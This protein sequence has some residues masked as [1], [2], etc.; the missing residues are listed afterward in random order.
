MS[1]KNLIS[2]KASVPTLLLLLLFCISTKSVFAQTSPSTLYVPLIG[3]TSIP[4]SLTLPGVGGDVTYHYAIKNFLTEV[5]LTD[6]QVVDDICNPIIFVEGD[7]NHDGKLDYSETWRYNCTT[8]LSTTTE[9]TATATGVANAITATHRAY[10]TVVVGQKDPAPLVSIINI[11]KVSYPLSL[12]NGGGPITF[13]YKVNNPGVVPL[14]GVT[15]TDDNCA[16]MSGKLGDTNGNNLL[17]TNEVWVFS[18]T[19]TLTHTTTNTA[20]VTAY[21]HGLKAVGDATLTVTVDTPSVLSPVNLFDVS[22]SPDGG[23]SPNLKIIVWA[24]LV[25]IL[26][27]LSIFSFRSK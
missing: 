20:M 19:T 18:C 26:A 9:S 12:P 4:S 24:I 1:K 21:A 22:V 10:A 11:T 2:K 25:A 16:P 13:T 7:D 14:H 17:D 6:V 23:A 3:I 15:V 27:A 5:A 8:R